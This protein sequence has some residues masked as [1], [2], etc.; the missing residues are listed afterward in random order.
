MASRSVPAVAV[1]VVSLLVSAAAALCFFMSQQDSQPF[2]AEHERIIMSFM[3]T[4]STT[5]IMNNHPS[6]HDSLIPIQLSDIIGLICAALGLMLAAGGGIGGGGILVPVYILILGFLPK[7]AIPLSNVTVF[8]GAIANTLRNYRKRHPTADRPL[9]D[10]DL[11]VVMEPPTL[12][13]TLIGANLNKM[14]PETVIAVMLVILL[15][16]TAYSTLKKAR[17][18]YQKETE[19]IKRQN[20]GSRT[21]AVD[22]TTMICESKFEDG[23][24]QYLLINDGTSS[25][26]EG[27]CPDSN[28]S[29]GLALHDIDNI[30][31]APILTREDSSFSSVQLDVEE[32]FSGEDLSEL[33]EVPEFGNPISQQDILEEERHPNRRN[34]LLVAVLFVVVLLVNI[35]KGGG[36]FKSP[37]GIECGSN[38]FWVAQSL[39]FVWILFISW[40]GRR[41]LLKDAARKAEAGYIYLDE[42]VRWNR[43]STVIYPQIGRARVG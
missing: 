36:G 6:D 19:E 39:L 34:I 18:M 28:H 29:T 5:P 35:L 24:N 41:F 17:R 33:D 9:I 23:I 13:G 25:D 8:G 7:H 10:W 15:V 38:A 12:A 11:I 43:K 20:V 31:H 1:A 14:L 21:F 2:S 32:D 3:E 16:F 4:N 37:L 26:D 40:L 27:E 30:Q 42:D 22:S